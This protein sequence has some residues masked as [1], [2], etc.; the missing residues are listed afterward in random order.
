MSDPVSSIR[1][2][3][4]RQLIPQG[5]SEMAPGPELAMLLAGI[6]MSALTGADAVLPF[7]S[8]TTSSDRCSDRQGVLWRHSRTC[9]VELAVHSC[10]GVA[11]FLA[12]LRTALRTALR[13]SRRH[14]SS[15]WPRRAAFLLLVVLA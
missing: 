13:P 4:V 10:P 14:A 2:V 5:L 7:G 6:D 15:Y 8:L 1:R 3:T 11:L 12:A 9:P